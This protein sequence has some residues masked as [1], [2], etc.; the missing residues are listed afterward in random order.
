MNEAASLER[1]YRRVL[2]CYPKAFRQ[3][4]GEEILSVLLSSAQQGQRRVGLAESAALIRGALRMR[5]RP[6]LRP[7]RTVRGAARLM[8]AGA[9]AELAAV[10]TIVVTAASVRA[11]LAKAPGVTAAQWHDALAMLTFKEVSGGAAVVLWLL[12]AWAISQGRDVARFSFSAF[13]ALISMIMLLGLAQ[14]AA[15]YAPADMIAGAVLWVIA[16]AT[17]VLI[18]ARPSNTYYRQAAG[19]R[20][21]PAVD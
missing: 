12:L 18:F 8:C 11:A 15:A 21:A 2:A 3:E 14:R 10:I 13:F 17:M 6:A 9:V 4:S 19:P 16:L 5:L 20:L 7:P 1:G